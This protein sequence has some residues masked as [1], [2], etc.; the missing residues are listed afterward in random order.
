MKSLIAALLLTLATSAAQAGECSKNAISAATALY[1][2]NNA[3]EVVT[4]V[5]SKLSGKEHIDEG[6]YVFTY[7][8]VVENKS[9]PSTVYRISV[10]NDSVCTVMKFEMPFAG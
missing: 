4:K 7:D 3:S 8:I 1:K 5:N 2:I 6:M 9:Y 10:V